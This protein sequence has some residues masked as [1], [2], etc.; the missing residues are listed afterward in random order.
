MKRLLVLFFGLAFASLLSLRAESADD[1]FI[2]VYNL[3]QQGDSAQAV[4]QSRT[5]GDRY[6]EAQ[7]ILLTLEREN[8][9]W[10][11]NIVNYRKKY[12]AERLGIAAP[13]STPTTP[14]D[15]ATAPTPPPA[16]PPT[17]ALAPARDERDDQIT[18]LNQEIKGLRG[19]RE[20]LQAKLREA[21]SVQPTPV[22]PRELTAVENRVKELGNENVTLRATITQLQERV[23]Q[24]AD[25]AALAEARQQLAQANLRLAQQEKEVRSLAKSNQAL[26]DRLKRKE[27]KAKPGASEDPNELPAAQRALQESKSALASQLET[28]ARLTAQNTALEQEVRKAGEGTRVPRSDQTQLDALNEWKAKVGQMDQQL[29]QSR[30]ELAAQRSRTEVLAAEKATL[31]RRLA[32]LAAKPA[33]PAVDPNA[34]RAER[35]TIKRLEK[36]RD[37]LR[38]K[39]AELNRETEKNSRAAEERAAKAG[40]DALKQLEKERDELKDRV[41]T[42]TRELDKKSPVP[43]E[44]PA[45]RQTRDDL[46]RVA[47]ERDELR[48]KVA[49]LNRELQRKE[50]SLVVPAPVPVAASAP[51]PAPTDKLTKA[52]KAALK[53]L[54]K[55]RS[56]LRRRVAELTNE[57]EKHKSKQAI[58]Q[59]GTIEEQLAIARARP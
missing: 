44:S 32:E 30:D 19:E 8:P 10:N 3:I 12:L 55:E 21:L 49:E 24:T 54:E 46:A 17:P 42:L 28:I 51:P 1:L 35:E 2:R 48:A 58:A 47:K 29:A 33:A 38:A 16:A 41:A 59:K 6:R 43:A 13:K 5:A 11:P 15:N 7:Q 4:G 25:P 34:T 50:P 18:M 14:A 26:E 56:D 27:P 52:D 36:E 40:K 23:A 45:A 53:R 20:T 9:G 57:L 39:V 22:D 37:E 31:E